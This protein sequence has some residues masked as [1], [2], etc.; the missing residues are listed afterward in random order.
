MLCPQQTQQIGSFDHGALLFRENI[1]TTNLTP[2]ADAPFKQYLEVSR[3]AAD[4]MAYA[5]RLTA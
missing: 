4:F 1:D 3:L 5:L 2:A